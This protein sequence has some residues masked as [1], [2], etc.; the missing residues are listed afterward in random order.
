MPYAE[1][2]VQRRLLVLVGLWG[3]VESA[4]GSPVAESNSLTEDFIRQSSPVSE[5][6]FVAED[7][8]RQGNPVSEN[9]F[10][11]EDC[12]GTGRRVAGGGSIPVVGFI[13]GSSRVAQ[14]REAGQGSRAVE[15]C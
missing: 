5:N 10:V 9:R 2:L 12:I 13:A 6:R 11:A 3:A 4:G 14:A 8:V 7:S 1:Q 15:G